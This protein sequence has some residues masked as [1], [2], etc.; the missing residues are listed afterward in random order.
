MTVVC[1]GIVRQVYVCAR[2]CVFFQCLQSSKKYGIFLRKLIEGFAQCMLYFLLELIIK[3]NASVVASNMNQD[4]STQWNSYK[5]TNKPKQKVCTSL[6]TEMSRKGIPIWFM[7]DVSLPVTLI[8]LQAQKTYCQLT[9]PSRLYSLKEMFCSMGRDVNDG[10]SHIPF[11][12]MD[13]RPYVKV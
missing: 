3:K 2:V 1:Q 8:I 5:V 11:L 6:R 13:I 12:S 4:G 7:Q 9:L 10:I